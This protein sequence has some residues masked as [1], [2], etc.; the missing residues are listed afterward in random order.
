M[1]AA[2]AQ[3]LDAQR[4]LVGVE[5]LEFPIAF[6]LAQEGNARRQDDG[7]HDG[8]AFHQLFGVHQS[9]ARPISSTSSADY[10][11]QGRDPLPFPQDEGAD[12][13]GGDDAEGDAGQQRAVLGTGRRT[14]TAVRRRARP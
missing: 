12:H 4:L 2:V 14:W 11:Q 3:H 5:R 9:P 1:D 8:H 13:G 7:D 10:K 6:V